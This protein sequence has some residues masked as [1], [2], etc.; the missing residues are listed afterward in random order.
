LKRAEK[1]RSRLLVSSN[2]S[3]R[4][5]QDFVF[6]NETLLIGSPNQSDLNNM[7]VPMDIVN[8]NNDEDDD[9][10]Q[11][12]VIDMQINPYSSYQ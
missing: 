11:K 8:Q 7:S 10:T 3:D 9:D 2:T 1:N 5:L 12:L 4:T 6:R